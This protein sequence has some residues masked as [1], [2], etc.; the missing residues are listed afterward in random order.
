[1]IFEYQMFG[2]NYS[3][4]FN[5]VAHYF[6]LHRLVLNVTTT[7]IN[8]GLL[9]G[10]SNTTKINNSCLI[11]FLEN[12]AKTIFVFLKRFTYLFGRTRSQLQQVGSSVAACNLLAAEV[13]QPVIRPKPLPLGAQSS[14]HNTTRGVP[15][16]VFLCELGMNLGSS[17]CNQEFYLYECLVGHS[18]TVWNVQEFF[19][20]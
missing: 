2:H 15:L 14:S 5:E 12:S 11:S 20:P 17:N 8:I 4:N 3:R 9:F 6:H 13:L 7:N 16:F 19:F 1:M 18:T 10:N